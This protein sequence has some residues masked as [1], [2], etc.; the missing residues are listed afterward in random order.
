MTSGRTSVYICRTTDTKNII[1][2]DD[3]HHLLIGSVV[4]GVN[5]HRAPF[6]PIH[7]IIEDCNMLV[8][9]ESVPV[10]ATTH[11]PLQLFN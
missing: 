6:T 8:N 10:Y 9:V 4:S 5:Q 1:D 2:R 7:S 3:I 11:S